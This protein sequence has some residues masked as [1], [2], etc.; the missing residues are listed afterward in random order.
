M[1]TDQEFADLYAAQRAYVTRVLLA[2]VRNRDADLAEDL[3]SETFI[4]AWKAWPQCQ[5][6]TDEQRRA[7]LR[8]IARRTAVDHYRLKRNRIEIAADPTSWQYAGQAVETAD[9]PGCYA[10][11]RTG[12]RRT[13]ATH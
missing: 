1:S 12:R 3:T 10:P 11:A 4:K 2:E 7:W 9:M 6:A 8:T 13:T 5:A